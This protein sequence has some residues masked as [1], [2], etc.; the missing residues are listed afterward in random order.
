MNKIS[1]LILL[2]FLVS[3]PHAVLAQS[4]DF[5]S[6]MSSLKTCVVE[7]L[8]EARKKK[9]KTAK[10]ALQPCRDLYEAAFELAPGGTKEAFRDLVRH[11]I[12][13]ELKKTG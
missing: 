13:H 5:E 3:A 12:E 10:E 4:S 2:A 6:A 9:K 11:N 1:S 7:H 8:P